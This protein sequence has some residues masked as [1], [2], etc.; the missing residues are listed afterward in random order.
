MQITILILAFSTLGAFV[1]ALQTCFFLTSNSYFKNAKECRGL[2]ASCGVDIAKLRKQFLPQKCS[3]F[4][5]NVTYLG[6]PLNDCEEL[7]KLQN[8]EMGYC[9]IANSLYS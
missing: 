9:Y 8:T 5:F 1:K 3:E 2:N 7:F 6:R 4:M